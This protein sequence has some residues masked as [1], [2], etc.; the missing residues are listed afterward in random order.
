MD[1]K[2]GREKWV[3]RA[4]PHGIE[5]EKRVF[6]R[7]TLGRARAFRTLRNGEEVTMRST[8][9]DRMRVG[10]QE[11]EFGGGASGKSELA[12]TTDV[13][14]RGCSCLLCEKLKV[15]LIFP[16]ITPP[17]LPPPP[18]SIRKIER[19]NAFAKS[20]P[21]PSPS[22]PAKGRSCPAMAHRFSSPSR[23]VLPAKLQLTEE[24][25]ERY[26]LAVDGLL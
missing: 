12:L 16:T 14:G 13:G 1:E 21:S 2:G 18:S 10:R 26:C 6:V 19:T 8:C 3:T 22:H 25:W 15:S 17:V 5:G 9:E 23:H 7:K 24:P 20:T 4:G 11:G